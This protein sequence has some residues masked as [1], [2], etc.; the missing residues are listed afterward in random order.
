MSVIPATALTKELLDSL[1]N[2]NPEQGTITWK[3]GL[4][5]IRG[6][7]SAEVKSRNDLVVYIKGRGYKVPRL[8]WTHVHGVIPEG[9]IYHKDGDRTNNRISNLAEAKTLGKEVA[10][11]HDRLCE[12]LRY[13]EETGN[14]YWKAKSS[15]NVEVGDVAG[16]YD[17]KKRWQL[18]IDDKYFLAENLVWFYVHKQWPNGVVYHVDGD[19]TNNR[20]RN[21]KLRG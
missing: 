11:T 20:K 19:Y 9:M 3:Y 13:E 16:G 4:L 5:H 1:L 2:F 12:V 21:L 15:S 10:L 14:F 6:G 8:M 7:I 18:R 17:W